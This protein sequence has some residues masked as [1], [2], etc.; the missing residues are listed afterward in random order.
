MTL[1]KF[2]HVYKRERLGTTLDRTT[3]SDLRFFI[4]SLRS[5]NLS[6]IEK[7]NPYYREESRLW[8]IYY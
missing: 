4:E 7:E 6:G 2:L 8:A 3:N 1:V 5:V